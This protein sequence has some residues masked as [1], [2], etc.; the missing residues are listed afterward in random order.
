M[1][2]DLSQN[3]AFTTSLIV[4][5]LEKAKIRIGSEIY[6]WCNIYFFPFFHADAPVVF[7]Y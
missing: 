7:F 4:F 5:V 2:L 3:W 6:D 1:F